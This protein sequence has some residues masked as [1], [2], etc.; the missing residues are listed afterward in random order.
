MTPL[1]KSHYSIGKS[2]LTLNDPSEVKEDGPDSVF[3]IAQDHLDKI[4]LVEDSLIGFLEALKV[5]QNLGKQLIFGL[6][7]SCSHESHSKDKGN[8]CLHKIIIFAKNNQGC[9]LLN[10]IYSHAFCQ[11]EG[12]IYIED[13]KKFWNDE[14][15]SISIPFYDSFI[16]MNSL[17]FCS[18]I[19]NFGFTDLHFFIE[20]N[21]LPF[22][23]DIQNKV[24]AYCDKYGHSYTKAKTIYYNSRKDF[25]SYQ[26]YKCVCSKKFKQ[27]TLNV[28]NFDHLASPEF[29]M[30]SYLE[31]KN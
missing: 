9:Q 5:S 27:R 7:I 22:D 12:V 16:F 11:T 3:S 26:T 29:C 8:E 28:P 20:D 19:P 30:E 2:I 1:F 14:N 10:K 24:I 15:L 21:F 25:E 31:N 4:V 17:H 23:I 6:R 18:C 13:L